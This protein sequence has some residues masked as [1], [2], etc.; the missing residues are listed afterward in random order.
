MN[1]NENGEG[2]FDI[3]DELLIQQI[4]NLLLSL[5]DFVYPNIL[6]NTKDPSF[7]LTRFTSD[8]FG[9]NVITTTT[10]T[11]TNISKTIL[12]RM[13][14]VPSDPRFPFKFQRRQFLICLCFAMTINKS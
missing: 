7:F 10:I 13:D 1:L 9:Q 12:A 3:F 6:E 11:G 8:K 4:D 5:V 14:L 2:E